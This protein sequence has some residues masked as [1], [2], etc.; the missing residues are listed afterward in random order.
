MKAFVEP[1]R[2]FLT[3]VRQSAMASVI[4]LLSWSTSQAQS[5][6]EAAFD[7]Y[8]DTLT[9]LGLTHAVEAIDYDRDVDVLTVK[10][11]V[12]SG[13]GQ[14]LNDFRQDDGETP[15]PAAFTFKIRADLCKLEGFTQED[16]TFSASLYS[17]TG[18]NGLSG[19]VTFDEALRAQL[20]HFTDNIEAQNYRV[21]LPVIDNKAEARPF[22]EWR[23]LLHALLL[24]S[25]DL[26][27]ADRE[28]SDLF[29]NRLDGE[30]EEL[31]FSQRVMRKQLRIQN[32][33]DG[34]W[35]R[36]EFE[37]GST[38]VLAA[39]DEGVSEGGYSQ[40]RSEL[41]GVNFSAYLDV[42]AG[43]RIPAGQDVQL[44]EAA[45]ERN[46]RTT[47]PIDEG[48]E[49]DISIDKA[50]TREVSLRARSFD[51]FKLAT[52]MMVPRNW[53]TETAL[54]DYML[55]ESFQF[56]RIF[57]YG[58]LDYSGLKLDI[59][60][61]SRRD[62][63]SIFVDSVTLSDL[64]SRGV[65]D[66]T[67][68]GIRIPDIPGG[69][70]A[71]VDRASLF[72]IEFAEYE[73]MI[74]VLQALLSDIDSA[75][76]DPVGMFRALLP[77]SLAYTVEGADLDLPG[78]DDMSIGKAHFSAATSVP[79]LP[80]RIDIDYRDIRHPL[81]GV[82]EGQIKTLLK[83]LGFS[84]IV[85]SSQT[86]LH[87]DEET[88]DLQLEKLKVSIEGLGALEI[89][90]RF[91]NVSRALFEDPLG[92]GE[93]ALAMAQFVDASVSL[94]DAGLVADGL[95]KIAATQGMPEADFREVLLKQ[96]DGAAT[97]VQNEIFSDMVNDAASRFLENPGELKVML[98][99]KAPVP[100]TQILGSLA[101]P[102]TLLDL[103]AVKIE[104]N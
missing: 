74:P 62:E 61:T 36:M 47:L 14:L 18:S 38:E 35:E 10:D 3:T 76:A 49:M 80:T 60:D 55:S 58:G 9:D 7:A 72:D 32:S 102:Q 30:D 15:S 54:F 73:P 52:G 13:G 20:W 48:L 33:R 41:L 46:V 90:A 96:I 93:L 77:R 71:R 45:V 79:P 29:V 40:G 22:R 5:T 21:S 12:V 86:R 57:S 91:A 68:S 63:F 95:G 34:Y 101:A 8:L 88:L 78:A 23:P 69:G 85:W 104:A 42:L 70:S 84:E 6:G 100:L 89:D 98:T 56:A 17:C 65:D 4:T 97:Q 28:Q 25:F 24:P 75:G 50:E 81:E 87:W 82:S 51:L 1:G 31:I 92:Q 67:V 19:S 37:E 44:V 59:A 66:L 99:P 83:T 53:Q 26:I 27:T 16:R 39:V 43:D 103:L 2:I 64:S 11:L 94:R